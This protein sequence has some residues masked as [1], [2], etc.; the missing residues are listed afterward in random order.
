[1]LLQNRSNSVRRL[2]NFGAPLYGFVDALLM[3]GN[4]RMAA[5]IKILPAGTLLEIGVG[6]GLRLPLFAGHKVTGID[7]SEK[8]LQRAHIRS[9]EV[10]LLQMDGADIQFA[11]A[12]FDTVV[13]AHVLSVAPA[14]NAVLT[15]AF[16]VLKSGGRLI[17]QNYFAPFAGG[18]ALAG[19]SRLFHLS[20]N[21]SLSSLYGLNDFSKLHEEQFGPFG[22]FR[23]LVFQKP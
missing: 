8:M 6:T 17:I 4:R 11:D 16:R 13:L 10:T 22:C 12:S 7:L 18:K 19:I 3:P 5:Q 20:A 9:P 21:F 2:Y 23:L 1:M 15:E 14:P